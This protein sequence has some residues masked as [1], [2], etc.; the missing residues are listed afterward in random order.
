M[1]CS[2]CYKD[3]IEGYCPRCRKQLFDG[4]NISHILDFDAPKADNLPLYQEK[5]KRLSI[6]GVQ[7]KYS[8]KLEGKKLV[9]TE[10]GGQ[11][12]LKPIPPTVQIV[13]AE[14]APE[15]EHL[16]MQIASKVYGINTA[17]NGVIYFKDGTA[18]YLTRRFDVKAD[19]TKYLQEDMAQISGRTRQ[20]AGEN[21]K[22][23]GTY[24][25]IGHLIEKYVA[26]SMPVKENYF[27]LVVFN[28]LIS[29]GDA[30]LKNFSLLQTDLGDY[31]LSPAY[32]LMSTVIHLPTETDVALQLFDGDLDEPFYSS[33][34]FYGQSSFREL[35]KKI[36]ILPQRLERILTHLLSKGEDVIKMVE[37][38]GLSD[39]VK[40]T[41]INAYK[42]KLRRMGMTQ[43]MIAEAVNS[44]YPSVYAVTT[45]PI[46]LT[47][48]NGKKITGYFET[49]PDSLELQKNNKYT[50]V[51]IEKTDLRKGDRTSKYSTIEGDQLIDV[52]YTGEL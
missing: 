33:Y 3:G 32:D 9:L 47:F 39:K 44:E 18:A 51:S 17:A 40:N 15:N 38:S 22:Y 10:T 23:E 19:G 8:L 27:R 35:G 46:T 20:T 4:K 28:Y 2:G 34:G 14:Q 42:D 36:G 30:H 24:E 41:Y 29:N 45:A 48:R 26:A 11:Y 6:S 31:T 37:D 7:L 49:T 16:T 52:A 5:T 50:F 1:K 13:E 21:F 25:E 43:T 12:I